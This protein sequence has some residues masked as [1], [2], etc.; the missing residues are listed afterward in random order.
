M[1][2]DSSTLCART[3][4]GEAELATPSQGLSLGQRRV[5][6][7]MQDPVAV[8][9]L[10]QRHRLE[11]EKLARD[12]TRLAELRLIVL[13]GPVDGALPRRCPLPACRQSASMAPVVIGPGTRRLPAV[14]LAVGATALVLAVGIWYGTRSSEST[15]PIAT[16]NV[17]APVALAVPPAAT[18]EQRAATV[19]DTTPP[20][21]A[22][23]SNLVAPL[24]VTR[25]P[26][27]S[28]PPSDA[29][30]AARPVSTVATP[31]QKTTPAPVASEQPTTMARSESAVAPT[32]KPQPVPSPVAAPPPVTVTVPP[33]AAAASVT[34]LPPAATSAGTVAAPPPA[35]AP[36]AA[37]PSPAAATTSPAAAT[38]PREREAPVQLAAA[39]QST[40]AARP[41]APAGLK[42]ISREPPD[43]PKEAI[44]DGLRSGQVNA[45]IHVDA[46]GSVT[47]VDILASQPPKVFDRAARRA[48]LRWQFEPNAAGQSAEADVEVKFQRD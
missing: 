44:A 23:T 39:A 7:L 26:R 3:V 13:Q 10:A 43:F 11:P 12:L 47:A 20:A 8:D 37:A 41:A 31:P 18:P 33:L 45:R 30:L 15:T 29:R 14:P 35:A 48:L 28:P 4:S 40:A 16:K 21:V 46:R 27:D 24:P 2:F 22:P 6:A 25:V 38:P 36:S 32:A 17:A 9:E 42:A 19:P 34:A 5:L 1:A